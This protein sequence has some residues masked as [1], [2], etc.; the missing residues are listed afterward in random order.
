MATVSVLVPWRGGQ[1]DRERAW[2]YVRSWWTERH[3]DW[4]VIT[5]SCPDGP[6]RKAL[7]VED[8]LSRADGDVLVIAD[9][10]VIADGVGEAVRAVEA[11]APWAIPHNLLY[12]L[13]AEATEDVLGG[14]APHA[15]MPTTQPPYEGYAGGGAAV[16][17]R[18][19]YER[20]PLD[21]R[22][23]G[24]GAEDEAAAFAWRSLVGGP[25]RG[26]APMW[27]LHHEPQPRLNRHV[28]S[29]ESHALLVRYQCAFKQGPAAMRK[30]VD[31]FQ[32]AAAEV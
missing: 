13:T 18:E 22:F 5:G 23:A 12:R 9:A 32:P 28:G 26:T 14:A 16:L 7:A 11:G 1:P 20:H 15:R 3:P 6:W 25:W 19:A 29:K 24:W 10:D 31:E 2:A 21:P 8:A 4:Q 27:H 30:L 17:R